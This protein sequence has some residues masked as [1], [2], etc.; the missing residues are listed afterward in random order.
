M[1][2]IRVYV[3]TV[4]LTKRT[5]KSSE[6]PMIYGNDFF[7]CVLIVIPDNDAWID[8]ENLL[9]VYG[10]RQLPRSLKRLS[11]RPKEVVFYPF[12][13]SPIMWQLDRH[14]ARLT[15]LSSGKDNTSSYFSFPF[16]F[17]LLFFAVTLKLKE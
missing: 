17:T 1:V 10:E 4:G 13:T 16:S 5:R 14:L 6:V 9:S 7:N 12:H 11:L 15:P 8:R 2:K 3:F